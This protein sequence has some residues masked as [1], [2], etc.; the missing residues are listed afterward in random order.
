[1]PTLAVVA[2][3]LLMAILEVKIEIEIEIEMGL[4]VHG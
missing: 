2:P 3:T 4:A 1:M